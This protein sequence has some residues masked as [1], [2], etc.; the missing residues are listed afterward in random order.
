MDTPD[1]ETSVNVT[2]A[3][4]VVVATDPPPVPVD[5]P[6]PEPP[7]TTVSVPDPV[8][9]P[10][11]SVTTVSVPDPVP[12]QP[13]A[14]VVSV[15]EHPP[16]MAVSV[17][18]HVPEPPVMVVSV[19]DPVPIPEPPVMV[20][21]V[22]DPVPEPPVMVVSVPIPEPPAMV[23]SVPDPVPEPPVITVDVPVPVPEPPA[24]VVSVPDPVFV[25]EPPVMTVYAPNPIP[26]PDPVPEQLPVT[27]P[28]PAKVYRA[29][30]DIVYDKITEQD[31]KDYGF[32]FDSDLFVYNETLTQLTSLSLN[33]SLFITSDS[34]KQY[35]YDADG[36]ARLNNTCVK[37]LDNWLRLWG[38]IPVFLEVRESI[39]KGFGI[40]ATQKIL[41][42]T[43][44]GYYD[45]IRHPVTNTLRNPYHLPY[46]DS[47]NNVAGKIDAQNLTFSNFSCLIN[48]GDPS[49]YNIS[50]VNH[51]GQILLVTLR[52]V[53][54]GE[55]LLVSYGDD[56]WAAN[57]KRKIN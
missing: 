2:D 5:D 10:D 4:A 18:D 48:D 43:F 1:I 8:P 29:H 54:V 28:E 34:F 25:P 55:E 19:P 41:R 20:V 14:M 9:D 42:G 3:V 38:K 51:T 16:V 7:V 17:P 13:P 12:E 32:V 49:K 31:V 50:H 39:N 44:L 27:M 26:D 36:N 6:V 37:N 40:F 47:L 52:D 22:P 53:E 21:S 15:P 45:G 33:R 24:M 46:V 56:Y 11:P 57:G 23:V 30:R 35:E